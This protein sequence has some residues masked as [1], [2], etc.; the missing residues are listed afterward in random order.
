[1]QF[2]TLY[3]KPTINKK[4]S[5]ICNTYINKLF[6]APRGPFM[7]MGNVIILNIKLNIFIKVVVQYFM[8]R[9]M[10]VLL[11]CFNMATKCANLII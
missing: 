10:K 2:E 7:K 4:R 1:L 5:K 11:K 9:I 8:I 6:Y 3:G